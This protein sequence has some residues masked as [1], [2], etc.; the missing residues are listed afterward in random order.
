MYGEQVNK[1]DTSLL[2]QALGLY[3]SF[4]TQGLNAKKKGNIDLGYPNGFD[5]IGQFVVNI[6]YMAGPISCCFLA[7]SIRLARKILISYRITSGTIT[8]RGAT[9]GS[10]M[11]V[12]ISANANK[13]K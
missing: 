11:G 1:H 7:A 9:I 12:M 10:E 13:A 6:N 8:V 2:E 3:D 4:I 5:H